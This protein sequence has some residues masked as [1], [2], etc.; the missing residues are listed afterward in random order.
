MNSETVQRCDRKADTSRKYIKAGESKNK[1]STVSA[2]TKNLTS[3]RHQ[4]VRGWRVCYEKGDGIPLVQRFSNL[5]VSIR[6]TR[7]TC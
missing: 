4:G 1:N 3:Y 2:S 6:V 7:R 5:V